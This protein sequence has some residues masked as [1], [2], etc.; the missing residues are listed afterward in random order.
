MTEQ[1]IVMMGVAIDYHVH[2]L[3]NQADDYRKTDNTEAIK[4]CYAEVRKFKAL[5]EKLKNY[6]L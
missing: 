5:K 2:M 4:D 6:G 1:E 3:Y